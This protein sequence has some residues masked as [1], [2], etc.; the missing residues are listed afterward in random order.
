MGGLT[1]AGAL[2]DHFEQVIVLE[3][4]TLPH[5]AAHRAGTPQGKH[6]HA[7]LGG[8]Q[9]ALGDLFPGF[10]QTLAQAGAVPLR[11]G[12]DTR[13]ERPGFGPF[14]KHDHGWITY[15]MSRAL[16]ELVVR[17]H[18]ERRANIT[19]RQR[20]RAHE[21]L[22]T[23]D[24]VAVTAVRCEDV[25]GLSETLPADL[26]V[27]AS[28]RGALTLASLESI[29]RPLPEET[30]IGVDVGY[31]TGVFAIPDD[32]PTDWKGVF[33]FGQA[34]DSRGA[35]M[36][37]LEGDRWILTVGGRHGDRPPGDSDGFLSYA[38]ELRTPTVYDAI[39][40][41]KRLG[42][43]ARFGFPASVRRHFERLEAF[44]RGLLPFGD[45]I[46]RFNPIYGQGMSVAAQEACL[47]HRLLETRAEEDDPLAGLATTFFAEAQALIDGP[48]AMAAVPD[49]I[50]PETRGQRPADFEITLKFGLALT[51]LASRDPAIHKLTLEVQH[52]L[53]PR[54][55]YRDPALV[56]RVLAVMAEA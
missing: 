28:G 19:V 45:A 2:A 49:F 27:D 33:T 34:P 24:G 14:P 29:G 46:C 52:L 12:L 56:Q 38:R 11:V 26:I 23:P 30:T 10:E 48:W 5:D 36:L 42:E 20:C 7:L 21:I 15:S 37:P 13:V 22:A 8:G 50:H 44:P 35:L 6:V 39:K 31:A 51:R 4:D 16:I 9:R 1:A 3:R 53:K 25:D 18:V 43:I 17:Q 40:H 47:L 41:A 55:V 32:S 54:S